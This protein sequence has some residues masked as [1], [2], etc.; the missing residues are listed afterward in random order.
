MPLFG[1]G[2]SANL[3][4]ASEN[5]KPRINKFVFGTDGRGYNSIIIKYYGARHPKP[6]KIVE[7]IDNYGNTRLNTNFYMNG[8]RVF[9]FSIK[10]GPKLIKETLEKNMLKQDD[11]DMF[12]FHQA[13]KIIIETITKK[14]QIPKEKYFLYLEECG[15][16]SAST[17]P[18]ALYNADKE[19]KIKRGNTIMLISFG[20]GFSWGATVIN[21]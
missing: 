19:N 12:V 20:T 6:D 14:L 3:I 18:I 2:A 4:C 16:T 15:N 7:E 13:S 21:Y 1:D 11:I 8:S 5:S 17:I 10:T 9:L